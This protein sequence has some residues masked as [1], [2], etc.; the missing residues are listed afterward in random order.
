MANFVAEIGNISELLSP[1]NRLELLEYAKAKL[2]TEE[3]ADLDY[4]RN[5][6]KEENSNATTN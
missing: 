2:R 4:L 1:K 3:L 5:K 6:R